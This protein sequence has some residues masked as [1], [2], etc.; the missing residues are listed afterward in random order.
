MLQR[1][2]VMH[3]RSNLPG[4]CVLTNSMMM[5]L[6]T[7]TVMMQPSVTLLY[8]RVCTARRTGFSG[9]RCRSYGG[10]AQAHT[11]TLSGSSTCV[12]THTKK[13]SGLSACRFWGAGTSTWAR[14]E[15]V[16]V[17]TGQRLSGCIYQSRQETEVDV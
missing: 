5:V 16:H 13:G 12:H 2:T 17:D 7:M 1:I 14:G 8:I 6:H 15:W 9:G 3:E 10:G 4:V 11:H